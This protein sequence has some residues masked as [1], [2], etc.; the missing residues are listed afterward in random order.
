M[1]DLR[2]AGRFLLRGLAT[3]HDAIIADIKQEV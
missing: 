2:E 1:R 3:A